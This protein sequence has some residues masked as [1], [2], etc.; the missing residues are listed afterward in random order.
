[1]RTIRSS[2]TLVVAAILIAAPGPAVAQL[3]VNISAPPMLPSYYQP[4]LSVQNEIWTPGYW[5][6]GQS[7]YY[8]V[9][10]T[11]IQPPSPGLM[12]TPGYWGSAQNGYSWNQGY[13][14]QNVGY[15]GG[16]NYGN[17]YYGNGYNGG[18]WSGG[19]FRYNTAVTNVNTTVIRNVYVNRAVVVTTVNHVSYNGGPGGLRIRPTPAQLALA[20]QH[21]VALTAVQRQHIV[22]ASQNHALLATVNHGKPP[23][24]A[25]A[26]PMT[27]ANQ[28]VA[29][30]VTAQ[31]PV[32]AAAPPV[33]AAAPPVHAAAPPVHAAAPPVRAAA[34]PV[35][36]AAPPV[37]AAG[38]P[39]HQA[40]Q[41]VHHAAQQPV[42]QAAKQPAQAAHPAAAA[43]QDKP[44]N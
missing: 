27:P 40:A 42:H 28:P 10:G 21:H 18:A 24:V 38:P 12:Y 4:Q 16:V 1:V 20:G 33:H 39:V 43:H 34:P 37:H 15:Y 26:R 11:W 7:G 29:K 9:P 25:V 3:F 17:G 36:A 31:Q 8:W 30:P 22:V 19:M 35:H 6:Y 14:G 32:H 23:I 41:P 2:L 13:W 44:P 5:A